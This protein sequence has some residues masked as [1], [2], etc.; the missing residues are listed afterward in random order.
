MDTN[1]NFTNDLNGE[2]D[3]RISFN[4]PRK[5][6]NL[7]AGRAVADGAIVVESESCT[8][9][10][11]LNIDRARLLNEA[12][13]LLL[14]NTYKEGKLY[15]HKPLNGN[16]DFTATRA[17]TATRVNAAGLVDLVPYN[18]L[19]YSEQ[20]DNAAWA[21]QT[22]SI[23]SN[24]AVSPDG[25]TTADLV[26]PSSSD[27]FVR[28]TFTAPSGQYTFSVWLKSATGSSFSTEINIGNAIRSTITV[29]NDWQRFTTTQP[30]T[31]LFSVVI[32]G[33]NSLSTGENLYVWG[34]QAVEGTSARDYLRTETRLN[35]PRVDYSLGGCPNI[36]LEPQR[37]NLALQSSSFDSA[38]WV[39]AAGTVTANS[40]TSPSGIVD[41]DT[42]T[43]DGIN[44]QHQLVQA[45]SFT[46]AV[47]YTI[48]VYAKKNTNDFLQLYG[49]GL[50]FG[51]N[52]WANFDL[53]LGVIGSVGTSATSSI[54]SVGNGWFRCTMTFT[55]AS[56]LVNNFIFHLINSATAGRG[57][58]NTLSTSV[59]LWGAQLEAGA[60]ATSYIPTTTASV[61]RNL[62]NITRTNVF[63]NGLIT[64]AGGTW[65]VEIRNNVAVVRDLSTSGIFLNTG[66]ASTIGNGFVLRNA[67]ASASRMAIF[68]VVAG[69]LSSN[70]YTIPTDNAK[71][72][73]KWNG[74]TLDIFV[75]AV[76]VVNAASFTPT[77]M[78]NLIGEGQNRAAYINEMALFPTPL[79]DAQCLL[80]TS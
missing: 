55:S 15:S 21:K 16:G 75:N 60:Y 80:I 2:S 74:A 76:K 61:T 11:M 19:S 77:A 62:D 14:P 73:F 54:Q 24:A 9:E 17:T 25:T 51:S 13:L 49:S 40:T 22:A 70:L 36:L 37:T 69:A 33:F 56:T 28:Q 43:G 7:T 57:Q 67:G 8:Y 44:N 68:T 10:T 65:F 63:T 27:S 41:A 3:C 42:F 1:I 23:T 46:N 26:T 30:L 47:A 66:I 38:T 50:A 53:N 45:A 48:S 32:G 59:F 12:S 78:Q 52:V 71:I 4:L 31:T 29:T 18:L 39:K 5:I 72:A 58:T 6:Y 64:A 79:T 20:F 35:I 34:A